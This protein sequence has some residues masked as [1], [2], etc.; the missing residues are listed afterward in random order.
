M[1][2]LGAGSMSGFDA[3]AGTDGTGA[4]GAFA[5]RADGVGM[6]AAAGMRSETALL[7]QKEQ[8]IQELEETNEYLELKIKK[9]EQLVRLKDNRIA[10]LQAKLSS[11][12]EGLA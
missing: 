9:L 11:H 3:G 6:L 5:P 1:S 10:T 4:G 2:A 7:V 12:R 8:R